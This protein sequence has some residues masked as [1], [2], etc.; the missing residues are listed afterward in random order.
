[1]SKRLHDTV[2]AVLGPAAPLWRGAADNPGGGTLAA[3]VALLPGV[4]DLGRHQRDPAQHHRRA[5][6]R[7]PPRAE[8][9][10]TAS[11][12]GTLRALRCHD[13]DVWHDWAVRDDPLRGRRARRTITLNRPDA[14]NA[15]NT[16]ADRRDR[17]RARPRRRRRRGP[18][19]RPRP[20]RASTSPPGTTSRRSSSGA[21]EWAQM[22]DTPEGKLRHE[23][24]MYW[25]KCV[26]SR[27]FRK[28]TIAAVH[29]A[30]RRRRPHARL[31]VRPDRRRRRREVLQPG[32]PHDRRRR[33]APGRAVGARPPQGQ[34]VP[35]RAR[36]R[37]TPPRPSDSG[38]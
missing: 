12:S 31:H 37:S 1:M 29:G 25:D 10:I 17:R 2:M 7:P 27:N 23:Q 13:D 35:A 18:R 34:G 24:V 11:S 20:A 5:R 6:P 32:A 19:R 26:R 15:Q 30:V 8:G 14:A 36:R 9:L 22:R 16:A 4:V 28:P 33:R 38:S 3:L 21:D